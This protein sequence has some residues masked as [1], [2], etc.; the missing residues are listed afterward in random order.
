MAD[1][2]DYSKQILL[3]FH[4]QYSEYYNQ[5]QRIF[6]YILTAVII[7]FSAYGIVL[8]KT[9]NATE[10]NPC[11]PRLLPIA[12]FFSCLVLTY[13]NSI[14]IHQGWNIRKTQWVINRIRE[15]IIPKDEKNKIFEKYGEKK[16]DLPVFYRINIF[17]SII[18]K[19]ALTIVTLILGD[20]SFCNWL[21]ASA[22][23]TTLSLIVDIAIYQHFYPK[24]Q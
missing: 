6:V 2:I 3:D 21:I 10:V 18:L 9:L 12:S 16:I 14:L 24:G 1:N 11:D 20:R 7:I 22:A 13:L 15:S 23:L 8:E 17:S 19:I 4:N 5:R